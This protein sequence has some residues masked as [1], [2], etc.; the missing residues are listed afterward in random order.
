MQ[1]S[2][3]GRGRVG[4]SSENK[5]SLLCGFLPAQTSEHLVMYGETLSSPT[6][7]SGEFCCWEVLIQGSLPSAAVF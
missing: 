3:W 5:P 6:G 4:P 2:W 7:R 1:Q